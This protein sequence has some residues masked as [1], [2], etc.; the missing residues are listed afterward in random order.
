MASEAI[1]T[2]EMSETVS[3]G[4]PEVEPAA[5]QRE[6]EPGEGLASPDPAERAKAAESHDFPYFEFYPYGYLY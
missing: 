3:G 1:S 2:R 6:G 4:Q 5:S